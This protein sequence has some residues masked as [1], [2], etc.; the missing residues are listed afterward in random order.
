MQLYYRRLAISLPPP[1]LSS[2][3][4]DVPDFLH[5]G[6]GDGLGNLTRL[7]LE[8]REA[9][10]ASDMTQRPDFGSIGG[11]NFVGTLQSPAIGWVIH[12]SDLLTK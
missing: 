11:G 2:S 6:M 3:A 12:G 10:K 8:V 1:Y 7:K 5:S 9:A 4:N